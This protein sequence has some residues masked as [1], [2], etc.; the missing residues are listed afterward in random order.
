M[1]LKVNTRTA[2]LN[3]GFVNMK[4]YMKEYVPE[5]GGRTWEGQWVTGDHYRKIG[6]SS[7]AD[8]YLRSYIGKPVVDPDH[9]DSDKLWNE[10]WEVDSDTVCKASRMYCSSGCMIFDR[11]RLKL[12]SVS[13]IDIDERSVYATVNFVQ[14][15]FEVN[16]E[17]QVR[18]VL[19]RD[20]TDT[21]ALGVSVVAHYSKDSE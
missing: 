1:M 16:I 11:D 5:A 19:L 18:P 9:K 21:N 12:T 14:G 6:G 8:E 7:E 13:V 3:R 17:G 2:W 4:D 10:Y 15:C 20:I